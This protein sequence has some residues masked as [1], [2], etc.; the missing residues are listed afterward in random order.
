VTLVEKLN[1]YGVQASA[2]KGVVSLEAVPDDLANLCDE[3]G[4]V[5]DAGLSAFLDELDTF[6]AYLDEHPYGREGGFVHRVEAG[7]EK[8][9]YNEGD[10]E[11]EE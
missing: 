2:H 7:R 1:R 10:G 9:W 8:A 5:V 4:T 6:K 11:W 3:E